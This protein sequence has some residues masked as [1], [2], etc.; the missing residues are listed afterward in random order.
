ML[1]EP[2]LA[3]EIEKAHQASTYYHHLLDSTHARSSGSLEALRATFVAD[4][5]AEKL[6]YGPRLLCNSLRPHFITEALVGYVEA[7]VGKLTRALHRIA[8]TALERE[9]LQDAVAMTPEE[10]ELTA[11]SSGYGDV[12]SLSRMDAFLGPAGVHLVEYNAE[13]PTGV[14]Y[15]QRL[16]RVFDRLQPMRAFCERH[17]VRAT[18]GVED[19]LQTLL[20]VYHEW[21]GRETPLIAIVDWDH[22]ITR[23]EF[24]IFSEYFAA[25]GY[26]TR[27]VDPRELELVNGKLV[28]FGQP[29]N[30]VYR[31]LL[32]SEFLERRQEC[33]AYE[34]AYR[35]G[36]VC[37][38]NSFRNKFL[39]KKLVFALLWDEHF[40]S[41]L[42]AE[43]QALVR[44]HVPWTCRLLPG[45]L[46]RHGRQYDTLEYATQHQA[47]LVLKP[48]DDYGGKGLLLGSEV[49]ASRWT[50]ALEV[51]LSQGDDPCNALVLQA[52]IPLFQE[53]F[54]DLDGH[55]N[56]YFVDLDPF[57]FRE[58]MYGFLTRMSHS[59][60]SNVSS[61][62][63]QIPTYILAD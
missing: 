58:R 4:M 60:I 11:L 6:D 35:G 14:G 55:R 40:Q 19:V 21:G 37:F 3:H 51:F 45:K 23:G 46:S 15:N 25:R 56:R 17:S 28:A 24:E 49:S 50:S 54:T 48:N 8:R 9:E 61:G 38:V 42:D 41:L 57:F 1:T 52:R 18:D 30:L 20:A 47:E 22:V 12:A 39:H 26:P 62:G 29:I 59:S 27:I 33:R 2:E 16:F 63:G 5:R 31:R 43:E 13:C 34:Q 36:A 7:V 32:M 44:A 53:C 10:K